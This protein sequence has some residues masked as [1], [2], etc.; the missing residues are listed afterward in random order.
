MLTATL[1][2]VAV[3]A[4]L[5]AVATGVLLVRTRRELD[6][7]RRLVEQLEAD[8]DAALRPPGALSPAE[9]ALRA[10]V[11]TATRVRR[12]GVAGLVGSSLEDL[13]TWA[14]EKRPDIRQVAAPDGTLTLLFSDIEGSTTLNARLGDRTWVKVLQAHDQ[15]VRSSAERQR[16]QVVKSAGDG[17]MIAFRDPYSALLAARGIQRT[18]A[19]TIDPRLRLT[20]V[21]VRIGVHCG[22]VVSRD[23]DY[24]GRNVALAA[25]VADLADG[26]EVLVTE[27]V[28]SEVEGADERR[29]R[30]EEAGRVELRGLP[31]EHTL[32]RLVVET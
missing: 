17:F 4:T 18:L 31:G 10:V 23:G 20:P 11:G 13:Q 3:L 25:R 26:G 32:S 28:R 30:F 5:A 9:R 15:L 29:M 8:L 22:H 7:A 16:G 14:L 6:V 2:T 21:R 19:R 12:Q 1:T 24:L 27:A